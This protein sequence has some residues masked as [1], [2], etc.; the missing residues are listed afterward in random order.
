[1]VVDDGSRDA[2]PELLERERGTLALRV[3]RRTE[4]GGPAIAR[5]E[6]WRAASAPLVAFTDDDCVAA[7]DWLSAGLEEWRRH[8]GDAVQGRTDPRPDEV[9]RLGPFARTQRVDGRAP[10][11]QTCNIFY[12]R[13]LLERLGGFDESFTH[14]AEDTDLAWRALEA[15]AKVRFEDSAQV[16]HGVNRLGPLAKLR[17]AARWTDAMRAYARHPELRRRDLTYGIFWKGSHYLLIRA[18][19][20]FALR[21]RVPPLAAWLAGP[22]LLHL[23]ERG[24]VEGGGPVLAPYYLLHDLVEL[25]AVVRGAIRHRTLIL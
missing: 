25:V 18:L 13:E 8:P 16:Y 2:T 7:P 12:P 10:H 14:F 17:L 11:Y 1:V 21:R 6:G 24:R 19:I 20:G 15:G 23:M 4:P 9:H 3:V 22:Y 5:N